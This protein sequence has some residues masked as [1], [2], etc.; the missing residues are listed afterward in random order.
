MCC[1]CYGQVVI[2]ET[3]RV[4]TP[5]MP[6]EDTIQTPARPSLRL[7]RP[8][9]FPPVPAA[10]LPSWTCISPSTSAPPVVASPTP[11][12]YPSHSP[13]SSALHLPHFPHGPWLP[14][15]TCLPL[16]CY[17]PCT[18]FTSGLYNTAPKQ[19]KRVPV[20]AGNFLHVPP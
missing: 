5:G 15:G 8:T 2:P 19:Y 14:P 7:S 4:W 12:L 13:L 11:H 1:R 17:H 3:S 18:C 9:S 20:P 16:N 10:P 6:Y